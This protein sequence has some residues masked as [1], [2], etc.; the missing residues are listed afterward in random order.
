MFAGIHIVYS[1]YFLSL[2]IASKFA[3]YNLPNIN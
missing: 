2:P 3:V 1:I